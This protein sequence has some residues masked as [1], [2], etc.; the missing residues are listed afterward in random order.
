MARGNQVTIIGGGVFGPI[1]LTKAIS[2][3]GSDP[4]ISFQI[5]ADVSAAVGCVGA[6][7]GSCGANN[8]FGVEIAAGVNDTVTLTNLQISAGAGFQYSANRSTRSRPGSMRLGHWRGYC[9]DRRN[10][11]GQGPNST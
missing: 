8:G 11:Q 5:A 4:K 10:Y 3:A 9:A 6:A 7:P 1:V 2:I